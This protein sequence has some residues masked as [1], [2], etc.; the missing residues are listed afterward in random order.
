M[1]AAFR[2]TSANFI[3]NNSKCPYDP[4][5]LL[6][7]CNP[8]NI[9]DILI[10]V[11]SDIISQMLFISFY[12]ITRSSLF[13]RLLFASLLLIYVYVIY[14][15]QLFLLTNFL[16]LLGMLVHH[17]AHCKKRLSTNNINYIKS[18]LSFNVVWF[19][20][21]LDVQYNISE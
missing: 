2:S 9:H 20:F 7:R 14:I 5:N 8:N 16:I 15:P 18:N 19:Y 12:N 3:Q 21:D 1:H 10:C 13:M 17:V 6:C 11:L 4:T